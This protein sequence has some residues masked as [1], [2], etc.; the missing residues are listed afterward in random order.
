MGNYVGGDKNVVNKEYI[1]ATANLADK[2]ICTVAGACGV[3]GAVAYGVVEKDTVSGDLATV[4]N[5][6][7]SLLE[8]KASG[9]VT[10]GTEVEIL[11]GTTY[12]NIAGVSTS[13]TYAG[14]QNKASGYPIGIAHSDG[15]VEGTVL[16]EWFS[17]QAKTA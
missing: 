16:I 12:A 15:D 11:T 4:K 13:I 14:V 1:T 5:G 10:K 2:S 9:T 8:V 17:Q 3:S 6:A 7:G